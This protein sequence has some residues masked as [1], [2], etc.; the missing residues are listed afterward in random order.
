MKKPLLFLLLLF[1]YQVSISQCV[2]NATN[3]G[4]NTVGAYEVTGD[5]TVTLNAN[6]TVSL[7]LG[8]NFQTAAGPDVR[9][10]LVNSNGLSDTDLKNSLIA[11]L[12][13]IELGLVGCTGCNP[14]LPQDGAK[15]FTVPVPNNVNIQDFD[16]VFF[17]CLQFN[18]FWDFG[19]F[20]SFSP[21]NCNILSIEELKLNTIVVYPNPAKDI[22]RISSPRNLEVSIE[23][24]NVLGK[25][26]YSHVGLTNQEINI[27]N[28]KSGIYI[29]S[30]RTGN[31]RVSK[32]LVIE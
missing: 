28:L 26:V 8:S 3:F 15:S 20:T 9:A 7:D 23:I 30:A 29:L 5:I 11:D 6:N 1:T 25:K 31:K 24:A 32:K 2:T 10:F 4:N 19:S 12:E 14:I 18:A 22:I 16:R 13:N 17:Y 27:S 21:S